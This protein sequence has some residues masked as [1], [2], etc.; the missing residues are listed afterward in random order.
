LLRIEPPSARKR[1]L[2]RGRGLSR[3]LQ[4]L[5]QKLPGDQTGLRIELRLVSKATWGLQH[6][7]MLNAAF[8]PQKA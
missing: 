6:E 1:S 3:Q 2:G 7:R 8:S 4:P 5:I